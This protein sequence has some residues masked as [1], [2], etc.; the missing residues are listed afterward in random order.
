MDVL[1][2]IAAAYWAGLQIR[3]IILWSIGCANLNQY[4]QYWFKL[5]QYGQPDNSELAT[6]MKLL[7][8][9]THS[10]AEL[11][12]KCE[13]WKVMKDFQMQAIRDLGMLSFVLTAHRDTN[14]TIC[15]S[16]HEQ[17]DEAG[18]E[19]FSKVQPNWQNVKIWEAWGKYA[20]SQFT[21]I[22]GSVPKESLPSKQ[23]EKIKI[24]LN[25]NEYPILVD[26]D[27]SSLATFSDLQAIIR[28]F[29]TT[30]YQIST[31]NAKAS[32]PWTSLAECPG[33][34]IDLPKG[35]KFWE[36]SCMTK[37][38][39]RCLLDHWYN[40]KNNI[41]AK[42]TFR[43]KS[44]LHPVANKGKGKEKAAKAAMKRVF[45]KVG[46]VSPRIKSTT[47]NKRK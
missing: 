11:K 10:L 21:D 3:G 18:F 47:R 14:R 27:L 43:F 39:T 31:G 30:H 33:N 2:R 37:E 20:Q 40:Q 26:E 13:E 44:S 12:E 8:N 5:T 34:Y 36:P 22:D 29:L 23:K 42:V 41:N 25:N 9:S 1:H 45:P 35:Y 4:C 6:Y 17:N 38:E 19:L 24:P 16:F 46:M 32:V 7:V 28:S 15:M